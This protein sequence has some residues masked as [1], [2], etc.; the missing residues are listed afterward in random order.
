MPKV[1]SEGQ[2]TIPKA[3]RDCLCN[4]PGCRVSF[5]RM[6]GGCVELELETEGG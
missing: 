1:T 6:P 2:V 5:E 4:A 3:V